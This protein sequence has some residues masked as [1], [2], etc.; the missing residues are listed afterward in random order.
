MCVLCVCVISHVQL[1]V[2][3]W[4]VVHQAPLSL[5][6]SRQEYQSGLPIPTPGGLPNS[7]IEPESPALQGGFF[8][9]APPEKCVYWGG[10]ITCN[11]YTLPG[12]SIKTQDTALQEGH[13][14]QTN[15]TSL[16]GLA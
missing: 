4:T 13:L 6:F 1:F 10:D 2:T 8:S 16:K 7:R 3:P 9:T 5:E 15:K 12:V 11:T 14:Y